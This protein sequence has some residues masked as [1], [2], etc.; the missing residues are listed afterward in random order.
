MSDEA[1]GLRDMT[2]S[3]YWRRTRKI[4]SGGFASVWLEECTFS[5]GLG[6]PREGK[7]RAIKQ[8]EFDNQLRSTNYKHELEIIAKF[9]HLKYESHFVK[10]FGWYE[11]SKHLFIAMEYCELGDLSRY[12]H[13]N[14]PL[15][16]DHAQDIAR[17]IL[18]GLD[19]MHENGIAHRDLKP[20]NIFIKSCPPKTWWIKL[21]DFGI[22]K[23]AEEL[24]QLHTFIGTSAYMSPEIQFR[25]PTNIFAND[26]WA[27]GEIIHYALTK[28]HVFPSLESLASYKTQ[29]D[30]PT[31]KLAEAR[32]SEEGI[33]FIRRT[34]HPDPSI[35]ETAPSAKSI[36]WISATILEAHT[37]REGTSE[38]AE[39]ASSPMSFSP[40]S[41]G[42][43]IPSASRYSPTES[44]FTSEISRARDCEEYSLIFTEGGIHA[45]S[46]IGNLRA[47]RAYLNAGHDANSLTSERK[48]PLM[49]ASENGHL[50]IVHALLGAG[51]DCQ[52][53]DKSRWTSLH[54]AANNG[55]EKIVALLLA[56][57]AAADPINL[58]IRTPLWYASEKGH[59]AVLKLLMNTG[60]V[61]MDIRDKLGQSAL[62]C[63][64]YNGHAN[65]V[66]LL[67]DSDMVDV[68]ARG[69]GDGRNQTPIWWAAREGHD[70]VVALLLGKEGVDVDTRLGDDWNES[71]F[72]WAVRNGH[73]RIVQRLIETRKIEIDLRNKDKRSPLLWACRNG[74]ENIVKLLLDTGKVDPNVYDQWRE[75]PLFWAARNAHDGIVRALLA[76]N[77]VDVDSKNAC[78]NHETPLWWAAKQGND[79]T[80]EIL[81]A[82]GLAD[83]NTQRGNGKFETPLYWAARNGHTSVVKRLLA[84]GKVNHRI[85]TGD[86]FTPLMAAEQN[87]HY[88][89]VKLIANY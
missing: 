6:G 63:A 5:Q 46:E 39:S 52:A 86:G 25:K 38:L 10:S 55:H 47:I 88:E 36:V 69:L 7:L 84:T 74:H 50:E 64:A 80:L 89:I 28:S 26:I 12:F 17:Q 11:T 82:T 72:F 68:N 62:W 77:K 48:T 23:R 30:F 13:R 29:Q 31:S 15:P 45:A 71:P 67:L 73:E 43:Y 51:A 4:G 3:E 37:S 83:V 9:S 22:S 76:T 44:E 41:A 33:Q 20:E 1:P 14:P 87:G 49:V 19:I 34:M 53:A 8:I 70:A 24:A 78:G 79:S 35:R 27:L 85:K 58:D 42:Q 65:I 66:K 81:L 18:Y 2:R 57:G 75:T 40:N 56:V 16:E 21:G 32:I 61:D 54:L 60:K 59:D